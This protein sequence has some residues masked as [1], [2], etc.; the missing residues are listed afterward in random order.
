[1]INVSSFSVLSDKSWNVVYEVHFIPFR[2][3]SWHIL[4][5][6]KFWNGCR[7]VLGRDTQIRVAPIFGEQLWLGAPRR[8]SPF[9]KWSTMLYEFSETHPLFF[10]GFLSL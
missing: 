10:S 7:S 5:F 4:N 9:P 6:E 2:M 3:N 8:S 1:M